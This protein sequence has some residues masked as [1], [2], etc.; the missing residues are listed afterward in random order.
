MRIL[1]YKIHTD[2]L[3]VNVTGIFILQEYVSKLGYVHRDL[4]ARNV[5]VDKD[6]TA[7]ISDFGL[8][9]LLNDD[10]IYKTSCKRKLPIK[11]MSIEA[12]SDLEFT[13]ESDR[14]DN[15]L[16]YIYFA[17]TYYWSV[18]DSEIAQILS[19]PHDKQ[20]SISNL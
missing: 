4:A 1:L 7:K 3:G 19:L 15:H 2:A 16:I 11:W 12:I 14:F 20:I 6:L 13:T 17:H 8:S 5:L 10:H 9:R 18:A